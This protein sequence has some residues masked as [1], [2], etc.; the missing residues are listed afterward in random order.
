[1]S[2]CTLSTGKEITFDLYK[3]T[4]AEWRTLFDKDTPEATSDG[5][6]AKVGGLSLDEYQNLPY[7]DHVLYDRTFWEKAKN[8]LAD[9]KN[10][11]SV[12]T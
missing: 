9:S 3:M 12:P 4:Y 2:D 11:P 8:P 6:V 1:M 5:L 10:S 7:P